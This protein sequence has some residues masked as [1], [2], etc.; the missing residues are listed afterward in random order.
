MIFLNLKIVFIETSEHR[1]GYG[2]ELVREM[3]KRIKPYNSVFVFRL[4]SNEDAGAFY[5]TLGFK[6]TLITGL[7][8]VPAVLGVISFNE[9]SKI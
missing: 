1:K 3:C 8:K 6:E 2:K 7:Y 9:L 5:R 4:F